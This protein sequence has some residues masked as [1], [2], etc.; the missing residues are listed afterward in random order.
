MRP[1]DMLQ[2]LTQRFTAAIREAFPERTP[3][4][5]PKWFQWVGKGPSA[6][7]RFIGCAKLAKA[8]KCKP[9]RVAAMI[10]ANLNTADLGVT[11]TVSKDCVLEAKAAQSAGGGQKQE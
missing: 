1:M 6:R 2:V 3:L 4:I 9:E 7:F 11:V 8:T 10:S 5:G